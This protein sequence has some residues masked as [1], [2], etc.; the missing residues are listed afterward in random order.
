MS[1]DILPA[2]HRH[3]PGVSPRLC[4]GQ[5]RSRSLIDDIPGWVV[6]TLVAD[7]Q[8]VYQGRSTDRQA[9]RACCGLV[10]F[11]VSRAIDH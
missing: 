6:L 11:A 10:D 4:A 8:K 3:C 5:V 9:A 2:V 1:D 7:G